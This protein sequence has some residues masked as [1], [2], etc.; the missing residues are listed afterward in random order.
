MAKWV[1]FSKNFDYP[2]SQRAGEVVA[3]TKSDEPVFIPVSHA[4]A[5]IEAGVA[6]EVDAPE[7]EDANN[8]APVATGRRRGRPPRG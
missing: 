6:E 7:E 4:D 1:Q 2:Y 5:A 8:G 3:Y